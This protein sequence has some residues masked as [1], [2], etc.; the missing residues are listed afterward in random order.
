MPKNY[1]II[2]GVPSN[3]SQADIKAAYRRLVKE[4]HPDHFGKNHSPFLGIQEAYS[5][6]SDPVRRRSYDSSLQE[7][8][9][10]RKE[11]IQPKPFQKNL[12]EDIEPLIPEQEPVDLGHVSLMRSFD[13]YWPSFDDLFD[14]IF[15]NFSDIHTKGEKPEDLTVVIKLTP[16]Q[17]FRGG[18]VRLSVP[19]KVRCPNCR[20]RGGVGLYEC[21]R[22]SGTGSLTGEYPVMVSYPPGILDNHSV[23]LS[24]D[25]YGI[26]NLYL[27]VNF[28]ISARG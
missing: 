8:H 3:S 24:L 14:R 22:C 13:E 11:H 18:H 19:A 25:C 17:A 2:L 1:Y 5:V 16:E 27:T 4:F 10:V 7:S 12:K 26:Q 28:R 15:R 9:K 20:G 21:W 23:Q 6:L